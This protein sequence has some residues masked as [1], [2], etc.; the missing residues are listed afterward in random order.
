M[1][2][3]KDKYNIEETAIPL[4]EFISKAFRRKIFNFFPG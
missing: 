4:F 1:N 2:S 3:S